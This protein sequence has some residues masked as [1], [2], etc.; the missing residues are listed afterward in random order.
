MSISAEERLNGDY[1]DLDMGDSSDMVAMGV[2]GGMM[3]P[4]PQHFIF[5][6]APPGAVG[7]DG[8]GGG[9]VCATA[10][11]VAAGG[12]G[13]GGALSSNRGGAIASR[14]HTHSGTKTISDTTEPV[15]VQFHADEFDVALA[16]YADIKVNE[17]L[18][19]DTDDDDADDDDV[20]HEQ[21]QMRV[22]GRTTELAVAVSAVSESS[23]LA[24]V[25]VPSGTMQLQIPTSGFTPGG[26][27]FDTSTTLAT[28][29]ITV[30][31]AGAAAAAA[32]ATSS[33]SSSNS[34]SNSNGTG[35]PI[36][37]SKPRVL[38]VEDSAPNRKLLMSLLRIVGCEVFPA[39]NGAIA[40]ELFA[41]VLERPNT[42]LCPF[43]IVLM[44]GSM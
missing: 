31:A 41:D 14:Q 21:H 36:V 43:D 40:V 19:D 25:T 7:S 9:N 37:V 34:S 6:P 23:V 26:S 39:E 27:S 32:A 28:T 16:V 18:N 4:S 5:A 24:P 42:A 29:T 38:V 44:D 10:A 11:S 15:S 17:K 30:G 8:G 13:H 22:D 12:G 2:T 33:A 3:V 1:P 20:K 35:S